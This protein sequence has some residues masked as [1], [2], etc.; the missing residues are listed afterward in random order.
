MSWEAVSLEMGLSVED[1]QA[2]ARGETEIVIEHHESRG[3]TQVHINRPV[4]GR[5]GIVLFIDS[6]GSART[7]KTTLAI[8]LAALCASRGVKVGLVDADSVGNGLYYAT[9]PLDE[10]LRGLLAWDPDAAKRQRSNWIVPGTTRARGFPVDVWAMPPHTRREPE[11]AWAPAFWQWIRSTYALTIVD[12]GEAP[13]TWAEIA[14]SF[15]DETIYVLPQ[16]LV[17][18]SRLAVSKP[19]GTAGMGLV[20]MGY[21]PKLSK[22]FEPSYLSE[23]IGIPLLAAIPYDPRFANWQLINS[24]PWFPTQAASNPVIAAEMEKV[25]PQGF[26]ETSE[27]ARKRR[28]P[29]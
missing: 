7:G 10:G 14:R 27:T 12:S 1:C 6:L 5:Q 9:Q 23:I 17:V 3:E 21:T 8:E 20:I 2:V 16:D 4:V 19:R 18:F 15:A 13:A 28:W 11:S 24:V 29:F 25:V 22:N 26:R